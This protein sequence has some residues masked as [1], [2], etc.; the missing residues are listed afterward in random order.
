MRI[1]EKNPRYIHES[2]THNNRLNQKKTRRKSVVSSIVIKQRGNRSGGKGI[3][4]KKLQ[5]TGREDTLIFST[6]KE[7]VIPPIRLLH[8]RRVLRPI[9]LAIY[10]RLDNLTNLLLSQ[11]TILVLLSL[12]L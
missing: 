12:L 4:K 11:P 7:I 10:T 5:K 8:V 2:N 1:F 6:K 9:L 3:E